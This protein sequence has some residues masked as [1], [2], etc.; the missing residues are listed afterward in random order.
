MAV[1][2]SW[3]DDVLE[4]GHPEDVKKL[5]ADLQS[6]FVSKGEGEMKEYLGNKVDLLCQSD[7]RAKIK[8]KLPVLVKKLWDEFDFPCGKHQ[9][10]QKCLA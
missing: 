10:H 2:L 5:E 6:A 9:R 4:L 7:R 1:M 8:V 3:V